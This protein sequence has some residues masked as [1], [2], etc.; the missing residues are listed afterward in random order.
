M[1]P[2]GGFTAAEKAQAKQEGFFGVSLGPAILRSETAALYA[3]SAL[4]FYLASR[5]PKP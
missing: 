4:D 2:E 5:G 3:A 1:G